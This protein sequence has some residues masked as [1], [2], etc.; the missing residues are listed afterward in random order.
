MQEQ[1]RP[2]LPIFIVF[3]ALYLVSQWLRAE[4]HKKMT[5]T[6]SIAYLKCLQWR[7]G[8]WWSAVPKWSTKSRRRLQ[9]S[10]VLEAVAELVQLDYMIGRPIRIDP[11]HVAVVR[12]TLTR[13][14][15]IR[16]SDILDE[17]STAFSEVIPAGEGEWTSVPVIEAAVKII[18]SSSNR[19]FVGLPL[20][21]DPDYRRLTEEYA[22]HVFE[23]AHIINVFPPLLR[24][25]VG[26]YLTKVPLTLKHIKL[27]I[28]PIIQERLA[29][30]ERYGA[31]WPDKP[32][33]YLSWLLDEA[34]GH[35]R[36]VHDLA[37]RLLAANFASIHTTANA[38]TQAL[39]D[40]A[41]H[42]E[43]VEPLREEVESIVGSKGWSKES[44]ANMRMVDSFI[45]ESQRMAASAVLMNRKVLRDFT[46]SNGVVVPA[47]THLAVAVRS[48]HF[49][50]A[51]YEN[52]DT[53]DGFRFMSM[54]QEG[55]DT[56]K[57]S[58]AALG[59]D[60]VVFGNG[61]H[62]CPGR[63]FAVSEIKVMLAYV[64]I[65]YDV[66]FPDQRLRPENIWFHGICSPDRM[67]EVMFRKRAT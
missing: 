62:A 41:C 56:S 15:G 5:D 48:M 46:F 61:R 33:D 63:F 12:T 25:L 17:I 16:F 21:R 50:E 45:K 6:I 27:H 1:E 55:G 9:I 31:D 40:L 3:V 51:L 2:V 53:F 47:G 22:S 29:M 38:F 49:D 20:C 57:H 58:I 64:L 18:C 37:T 13:N 24:P 67:A 59:L 32:N 54:G 28:G 4:T 14:I 44:V 60:Y 11:Y 52:P 7:G 42:P 34:Q 39:Y 65:S 8:W 43:Y 66:K 35:Q 36:T 10:S 23:G 26:R 30:D 19:L